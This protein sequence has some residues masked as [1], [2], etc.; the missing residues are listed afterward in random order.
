METLTF[1]ELLLWLVEELTETELW[2]LPSSVGTVWRTEALAGTS[3]F[4]PLT[5]T[6]TLVFE[7][8]LT[9]PE[10]APVLLGCAESAAGVEEWSG[11]AV[12]SVEV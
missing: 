8:L 2:P 4:W 11:S 3:M 5:V 9:E 6:W 12:L 7:L 10:V 1:K